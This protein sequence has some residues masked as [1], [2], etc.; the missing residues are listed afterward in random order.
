MR[1]VWVLV[2]L[3][4]GL[5]V[6]APAI[7]MDV[8][9]VRDITRYVINA[10]GTYSEEREFA[11]KIVS[12]RAV[13]WRKR[14]SVTYSTSIQLGEVLEA[15]TLKLDGR[16]LDVPPNNYQLEINQGRD[17]ASP[18]YSDQTTMTVVFPDVQ[19]GDTIVW[20]Y[21]ITSKEPLFPS[22][23]SE[24]N[25]Y[26]RET[27]YDL[28]ELVFDVPTEMWLQTGAHYLEPQPT[29]EVNGRRIMS[30]RWSNPEPQKRKPYD[31]GIYEPEKEPTLFVTTF[32]TY[33]DIAEAYGLR[34]RKIAA[35]TPR[36]QKLADEV[37]K[38]AKYP[39]EQA[40][41]LYEWVARNITYAGNCIGIGAV[42]PRELD[43]VLDNRMGDCKD[44]A[45][46]YQS[47]LAAKGIRSIQ[48][49]V[50][51]G[52]TYTLPKVPVVSMV[53]HVINYL[54]DF[55]LY[56][57]ST[58]NSTPFGLLPF[59]DSDK[60]VLWVD[61]YRDGTRTPRHLVGSNRQLMKTVVQIAEDGSAKVSVK[62][63]LNGAYAIEARDRFRT[64]PVSKDADMMEGML[65]R[66]N[67]EG[68]GEFKRGETET[69][70]DEFEYSA[71]FH[72]KEMFQ[73]DGTGAMP[74]YPMFY[75]EAP[76]SSFLGD[77]RQDDNGRPFT[78]TSGSSVEE[79]ELHL[80]KRLKVLSLPSNVRLETKTYT[81]SSEYKRKGNLLKVRRSLDDR[82]EGHICGSADL[83]EIKQIG[84]KILAD[85]RSQ[86]VYQ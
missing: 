82:T 20:R 47:L 66:M 85:L 76:I 51:A 72:A 13:E 69:L 36:I 59:G 41:L 16:R 26:S 6:A 45:T 60:P 14:G 39:K 84:K 71:T 56:A 4:S 15:Y 17:K 49:L 64:V 23:F 48:A 11:T 37:T 31:F 7:D 46:L 77:L 63:S 30:W 18:V 65:K 75:N 81:Y 29:R 33:G 21:R 78:C 52:S 80:P 44:H 10:D 53:N 22:H 2:L 43:F 38:D 74:V 50:N 32:R 5:T 19:Q 62:V 68:T 42:V 58:S 27:A 86:I 9:Q 40:R 35:V 73:L 25:W 1:Y 61:G 57:D 67:L 28:V 34:A 70:T 12:E 79:Y 83:A 8:R 55:D 3:F 54:P 24:L